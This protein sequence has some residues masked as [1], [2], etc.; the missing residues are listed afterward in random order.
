MEYNL[1]I[2]FSFSNLPK[3]NQKPPVPLALPWSF[4]FCASLDE[5]KLTTFTDMS[6]ALVLMTR[7]QILT[8]EK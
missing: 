4:N 7:A 1:L 6:L 2:L 5:Q 8:F 3:I